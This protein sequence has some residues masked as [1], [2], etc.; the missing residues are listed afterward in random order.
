MKKRAKRLGSIIQLIKNIERNIE[1]KD[2]ELQS[3][4]RNETIETINNIWNNNKKI[5]HKEK[6][7]IKYKKQTQEF[8][9]KHPNIIFTRADKG[10]TTVAIDKPK[11]IIDME[12]I[13]DDKNTY[14][15]IQKD[16]TNKLTTNLRNVLTRWKNQKYIDEKTYRCLLET[17]GVL[18]RAYGVPKIHKEGNPLRI[19]IST[20][21]SPL[22]KIATYLHKILNDNIPKPENVVKNSY[23]LV[24][25][26]TGQKFNT[27]HSLASFDVI[28][29]FTNI[30]IEK[31]NESISKRW[32]HIKEKTN[33]PLKE[34][35]IGINL[36]LNSTYF[37]FNNTIYKQIYGTPM[38]SPLS[39]IVSDMVM[40]DLESTAIK[41]LNYKPNIYIRYVDDILIATRTDKLKETLNVFN[42]IEDR[43]K[44]TIEI[45][46]DNS[47]SFLDTL[48]TTEQNEII[49]NHYQKPTNSGRLLNFNSNH[50]IQHKR[51]II[52]NMTDRILTLSHH[53]FHKSNLNKAINSLLE[54]GYPLK[55]IFENMRNRINKYNNDKK[56]TVNK[57]HSKKTE[58]K[59][60]KYFTIP[61]M[62]NDTKKLEKKIK[63]HGFS[64]AYSCHNKLNT[65][66]KTGK[67]KLEHKKQNDIVYQIN[68]NQCE[69]T[70][71][72]QTG[73]QLQIRIKE[74][75]KDIN[76]KTG[77]LSVIS[78]HKIK[79]NHEFEWDNVK[80]LD[81]EPTYRKRLISEM[82]HIKRHTQAINKQSDTDF[83]PNTYLPTLRS[84]PPINK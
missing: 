75:R 67:D 65:Y 79:Y 63:E 36:I 60:K 4:V 1:R 56:S 14:N 58:E 30:P 22:Y 50:P 77:T 11:Y 68:C 55:F 33:I 57:E 31:V 83:L 43:L 21:N 71:I 3:V 44:F 23:E 5:N 2:E 84:L 52:S 48:I 41:L 42:S 66:I 35:L 26:L 59:E 46:P 12:K 62:K 16:P 49:F 40:Q 73:R 39:P 69:A 27:D 15:T 64:P 9:E 51:A 37:T 13:L 32:D 24:K 80:I 74:H 17:D 19:I 54:N 28:S 45:R 25:K 18:P 53:K 70:Y 34:F 72:G 76:K 10:N 47:I 8:I 6:L 38:G 61:Y 20:I 82:I 81:K 7:I 29:L 78:E